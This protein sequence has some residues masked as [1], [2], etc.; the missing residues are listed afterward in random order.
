MAKNHKL[1]QYLTMRQARFRVSVINGNYDY[2]LKLMRRLF[3]AK[4]I[5]I[6]EWSLVI[7]RENKY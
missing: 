6:L 3:Y 4:Y 1:N 5:Y 2:Y 7:G